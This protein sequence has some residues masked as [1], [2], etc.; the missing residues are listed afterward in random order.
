V[1]DKKDVVISYVFTNNVST[2]NVATFIAHF[3]RRG[4]ANDCSGYPFLF[5]KKKRKD[6][7]GKRARAPKKQRETSNL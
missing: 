2:L 5:F 4:C 1:V 6:R 7:S 3:L